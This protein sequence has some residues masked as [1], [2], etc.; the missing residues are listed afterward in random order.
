MRL[1]SAASSPAPP[2]PSR[3]AR[4]STLA[5]LLLVGSVESYQGT[6][7]DNTQY[8]TS[9][10]DG[11]FWGAEVVLD[12]QRISGTIPP[13]MINNARAGLAKLHLD[14]TRAGTRGPARHSGRSARAAAHTVSR[15][16]CYFRG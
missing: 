8:G 11:T 6:I 9:L 14:N 15:I 7:C 4:T 5:L 1:A 12:G 10:C 16:F 2:A 13:H 3:L